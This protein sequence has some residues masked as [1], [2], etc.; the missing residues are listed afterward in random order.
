[1]HVGG[2]DAGPEPLQAAWL[3]STSMEAAPLWTSLVKLDSLQAVLG[4]AAGLSGTYSE[5]L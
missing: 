4:W 1:M 3:H 5:N 2:A